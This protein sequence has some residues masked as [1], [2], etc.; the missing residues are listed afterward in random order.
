MRRLK[1]WAF[2]KLL[3]WFCS[4]ELDQWE[5]WKIPTPFGLV[6]VTIAREPISEMRPEHFNSV[7]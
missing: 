5:A 4:K 7:E 6:Y 2:F 1:S 3:R